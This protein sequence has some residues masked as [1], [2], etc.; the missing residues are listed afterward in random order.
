MLT[1]EDAS[2]A[3][4][5]SV[6]DQA[7]TAAVPVHAHVQHSLKPHDTQALRARSRIP[8]APGTAPATVACSPAAGKAAGVSTGG[9]GGGACTDAA[10]TGARLAVLG[11]I[12]PDLL[13]QRDDATSDQDSSNW[14]SD[15][16]SEERLQELAGGAGL[17]A[18][19]A[20]GLG[21]LVSSGSSAVCGGS[22]GPVELPAATRNVDAGGREEGSVLQ[23]EQPVQTIKAS[24]AAEGGR[25]WGRGLWGCM[26]VVWSLLLV[27]VGLLAAAALLT[28]QEPRPLAAAGGV[29][30]AFADSDIGVLAGTAAGRFMV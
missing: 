30:F 19:D 2:D 3:S 18:Q 17:P 29:F 11:D 6:R 13:S 4:T 25:G 20:L 26:L 8:L 24:G 14:L 15:G 12:A 5:S 1:F 9:A 7:S 21:G 28:L 22:T 10:S 16:C 23:A 27:G